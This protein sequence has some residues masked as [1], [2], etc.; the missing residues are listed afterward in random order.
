MRPRDGGYPGDERYF[1]SCLLEFVEESISA[2]AV[3]GVDDWL[4]ARRDQLA[5]GRLSYV[6]HRYDFLYRTAAD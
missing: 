3:P 5:D 4:A 2:A 1:L 6:G